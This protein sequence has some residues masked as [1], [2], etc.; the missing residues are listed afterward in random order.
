MSKKDE[1]SFINLPGF[2]ARLYDHLTRT[3][4]IQ[5][6]LE[7]IA[8]D[9]VARIERGRLL[10]IGSGPGRLLLAIHRLNPNLD[11]F[12]LDISASMIKVAR[13][14]L[15]GIEVDLRCG[16]I[17]HT[18]YDCNYF[19]LITC[20]GSFYLWAQPAACLDEI[21]RILKPACSAVLFETHRDFDPAGFRP[22]LRANLRQESLLRRLI[23]PV[24]LHKQLH[25]TYRID[26]IVHLVGQTPFAASYAVEPISL[27]G[28][29]IWLRLRLI[30]PVSESQ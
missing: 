19:D 21:F 30:K 1:A 25:M 10:D 26:E 24:L 20:T 13:Q 27:A 4:A 16:N 2:G 7:E 28:L 3:G 15:A 17:R 6:Q 23:T 5:R 18:D 9:L 14:N 11:L 29:P 12:G 8:Q 22:A